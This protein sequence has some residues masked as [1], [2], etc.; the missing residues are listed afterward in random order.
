MAKGKELDGIIEECLGRLLAG[1]ATI[2]Q[3][4]DDYPGE[5]EKLAPLL[6]TALMASRMQDIAPRPDFKARAR[7]E[8]QAALHEPLPKRGFLA[9][10][11]P[12]WA[13]VVTVV[14]IMLL[15]SGGTVGASGKSMPDG[16]LYP[17]KLFTERMRLA[18]ATS[19]I[20]KAEVYARLN[21]TRVG[22]I[23]TM[24]DRNK[25]Q[26]IEET[27]ARL[28]E[29]LR[30]VA[31]LAGDGEEPEKIMLAPAPQPAPRPAEAPTLTVEGGQGED[32]S[33]E[34]EKVARLKTLVAE[35]AEKHPAELRAMLKT[36][37]EAAK[38]ALR[39]ALAI[40]EERYSEALE[41]VNESVATDR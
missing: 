27:A 8:F 19:D 40:A 28:D 24:V 5:A 35:Y 37:P 6:E 23:L 25:P 13:T 26:Y 1:E 12:R 34:D 17:V 38:P 10:A 39:R 3:C 2:E 7:Y 41:A 22:E 18:L 32:V 9:F 11:W 33:E 16:V 29:N 14:V 4:L 21:E 31:V 20:A 30:N 36:A 15:V